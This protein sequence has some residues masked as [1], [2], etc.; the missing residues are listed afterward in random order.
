MALAKIP[1]PPWLELREIKGFSE[2]LAS[3]GFKD[4]FGTRTGK[5]RGKIG[6]NQLGPFLWSRW[7]ADERFHAQELRALQREVNVLLE[8]KAKVEHLLKDLPDL[9]RAARK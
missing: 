2:W 5:P 6:W 7:N 9:L 3:N 4:A 8:W 1:P